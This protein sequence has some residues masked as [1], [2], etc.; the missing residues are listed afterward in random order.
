[1]KVAGSGGRGLENMGEFMTSSAS[2]ARHRYNH[3]CIT[4]VLRPLWCDYEELY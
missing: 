2:R 1:M 3:E 4:P